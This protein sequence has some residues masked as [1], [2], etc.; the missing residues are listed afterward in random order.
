MIEI[1]LGVLEVDLRIHAPASE[2]TLPIVRQALRSFG[3]TVAAER[4]ALE[5]AELA[6]TEACANVVEHAYAD[7]EGALEVTFR[8]YER[9]MRVSVRDYGH[10]IP[11]GATDDASGF[12]LAMIEAIAGE[13][14][15]RGGDGTEVTMAFDLGEPDTTTVDGAIPGL[16]PSERILRR[17]VAVVGAQIDLPSDQLMESLLV[18]ELVARHALRRLVGERVEI[19]LDTGERSME[20]SVGPL[21]IGGAAAVV[22][23]SEVPV[24]GSVVDRLADRIETQSVTVDGVECE[25]LVIGIDVRASR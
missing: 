17:L 12:G 14:E 22:S 8:A 6:L 3:E 25:R 15:I 2:D 9:D 10:G 13:V 11:P 20:L 21:E 18:A 4:D 24:V 16:K 7:G 1:E 19:R 23:D 5:D